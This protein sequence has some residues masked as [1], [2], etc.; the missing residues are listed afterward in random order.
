[1]RGQVDHQFGVEDA[2][3]CRVANWEGMHPRLRALPS[4]L[5]LRI[6]AWGVAGRCLWPIVAGGRL[7]RASQDHGQQFGLPT[8]VDA[9]GEAESLLKGRHVAAVRIRQETA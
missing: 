3:E 4:Q 9:Y 2:C 8:P 5:L 7:V 6:W 1:M